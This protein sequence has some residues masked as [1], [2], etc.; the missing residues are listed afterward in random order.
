MEKVTRAKQIYHAFRVLIFEHKSTPTQS[1]E[2]W[3]KECASTKHTSRRK[4][5]NAGGFVGRTT[6]GHN[7]VAFGAVELKHG[8]YGRTE[9]GKCKL[10]ILGDKTE[11]TTKKPKNVLHFALTKMQICTCVAVESFECAPGY[12]THTLCACT[13]TMKASIQCP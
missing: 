4:K 6:S 13:A 2:A 12:S 7:T 1:L 11:S 9:T 5:R 8:Y 3:A 10:M